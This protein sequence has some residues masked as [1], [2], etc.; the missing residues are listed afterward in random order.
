MSSGT[1][2]RYIE[3]ADG[4]KLAMDCGYDADVSL[5]AWEIT[6]GT[7]RPGELL[8][9]FLDPEKTAEITWVSGTETAAWAGFTEFAAIEMDRTGCIRVRMRKPMAE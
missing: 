7:Y 5:W 6:P 3:L 1:N 2:D 4:T 9:L 8:A